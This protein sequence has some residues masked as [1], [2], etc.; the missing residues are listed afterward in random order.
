MAI[1]N[2]WLKANST[3]RDYSIGSSLSLSQSKGSYI[4]NQTIVKQ[5]PDEQFVDLTK[6]NRFT[7]MRRKCAVC[8]EMILVRPLD[9]PFYRKAEGKYVYIC[10]K[11]DGIARLKFEHEQKAENPVTG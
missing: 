3:A 2:H 1:R 4:R 10:Q 5:I 6:T 9:W 8:G 7:Y 11:C